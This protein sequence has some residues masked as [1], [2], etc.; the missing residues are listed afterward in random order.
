MKKYFSLILL[1][2]GFFLPMHAQDQVEYNKSGQY[3]RLTFKADFA[4]DVIAWKPIF[5][6]DDYTVIMD[7]L[8]VSNQAIPSSQ[9]GS[10]NEVLISSFTSS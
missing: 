3:W 6:F 9:H 5:Y 10:L 1:L 4:N 7:F 2:I 8:I